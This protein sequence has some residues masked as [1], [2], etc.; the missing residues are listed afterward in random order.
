MQNIETEIKQIIDDYKNAD[1]VFLK[2]MEIKVKE[3]FKEFFINH[4]EVKKLTW[5]Q[6]TDYFNDGDPTVFRPHFY[7][8]FNGGPAYEDEYEDRI[9]MNPE[10]EKIERD[11]E[12]F[13]SSIPRNVW[14]NMFGDHC[15]VIATAEGFD[16]EEYEHD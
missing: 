5:T 14:L 12:K 8:I 11:T 16:V 15:Q 1:E 7:N 9:V 6:Y 2:T 10:L 3:F 13:L 4:S